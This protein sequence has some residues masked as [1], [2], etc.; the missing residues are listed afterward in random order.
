MIAE[1]TVFSEG[2]IIVSLIHPPIVDRDVVIEV[3]RSDRSVT[4]LTI[5]RDELRSWVDDLTAF[6][7]NLKK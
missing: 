3:H 7:R 4:F 5:T 2:T 6:S 1:R